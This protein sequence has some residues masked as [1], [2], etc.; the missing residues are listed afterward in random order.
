[1]IFEK[2]NVRT[3]LDADMVS[4][5]DTGYFADCL[6]GLREVVQNDD[7]RYFGEIKK[8]LDEDTPTL[9]RFWVKNASKYAFFYPVDKKKSRPFSNAI[10]FVIALQRHGGLIKGQVTGYIFNPVK[11]T[12]EGVYFDR[13]F[14]SYSDLC[15]NYVFVDGSS[16][17]E[18]V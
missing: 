3:V 17:H 16:I 4:V 9:Y 15:E 7:R 11:I 8:I 13:E 12:D 6:S 14:H 1:M 10:S 18:D 5:G 2:S